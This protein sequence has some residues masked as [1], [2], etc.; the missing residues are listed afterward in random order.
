MHIC[1]I[2]L[3]SSCGDVG[4]GFEVNSVVSWLT[5]WIS[6]GNRAVLCSLWP[7]GCSCS[8]FGCAGFKVQGSGKGPALSQP[9]KNGPSLEA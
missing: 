4:L 8:A 5:T 9:R 1:N 3:A 2:A 7:L 6:V